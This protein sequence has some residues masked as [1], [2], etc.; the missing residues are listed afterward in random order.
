MQL[1]L[2]GCKSDCLRPDDA[3]P[4]TLSP[5]APPLR[6][7]DAPA[8]T[9]EEAAAAEYGLRV[10]AMAHGAGALLPLPAAPA[11]APAARCGGVAAGGTAQC[12]SAVPLSSGPGPSIARASASPPPLPR[13]FPGGA[14]SG[15]ADSHALPGPDRRGGQDSAA[16][17]GALSARV[18]PRACCRAPG[19]ELTGPGC[20]GRQG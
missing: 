19:P 14:R 3:A 7:G 16:H 20:A 18:G 1:V 12:R 2:V 10:L 17:R 11:P 4:A 6:A 5:A 8:V 9:E 15:A 13:P